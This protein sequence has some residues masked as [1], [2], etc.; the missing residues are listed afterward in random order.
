M[1]VQSL[2]R[3]CPADKANLA[4]RLANRHGQVDDHSDRRERRSRAHGKQRAAA[5]LRQTGQ[6]GGQ[7][8][9]RNADALEGLSEDLG[10]LFSTAAS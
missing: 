8:R 5:E 4:V 2:Q 6:I 1:P 3:P 9:L 10:P 7:L